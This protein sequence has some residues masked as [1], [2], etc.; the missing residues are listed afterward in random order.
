MSY[1]SERQFVRPSVRRVELITERDATRPGREPAFPVPVCDWTD[2]S[3][4]AA[5]E[6]ARTAPCAVPSGRS[7]VVRFVCTRHARRPYDLMA[8]AAGFGVGT[9]NTAPGC[10]VYKRAGEVRGVGG[11][12]M[13]E[14]MRGEA[15]SRQRL[16]PGRLHR[17]ASVVGTFHVRTVVFGILMT[18]LR[19]RSGSFVTAPLALQLDDVAKRHSIDW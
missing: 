8:G 6:W 9:R 17:P 16:V 5:G 7:L 2:E 19:R 3:G 15:G 12:G 11:S 13:M 18:R 4:S 10:G 14:L 1:I